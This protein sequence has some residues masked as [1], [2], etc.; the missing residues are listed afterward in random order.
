MPMVNFAKRANVI[1]LTASNA[2]YFSKYALRNLAAY[3]CQVSSQWGFLDTRR[4]RSDWMLWLLSRVF[5]WRSMHSPA[6]PTKHTR[7]PGLSQYTSRRI[8]ACAVLCR[9]RTDCSPTMS[10]VFYLNN[11]ELRAIIYIFQVNYNCTSPSA[12][13]KLWRVFGD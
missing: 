5:L 9:N 3:L 13:F 6:D 12:A 10:P 11:S 1:S 8:C 2:D 4:L 7:R